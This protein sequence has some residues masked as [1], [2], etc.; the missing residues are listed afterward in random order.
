MA[1]AKKKVV[2]DA[3]FFNHAT[4]YEI[5]SSFFSKI[6]DANGYDPAMHYFVARVELKN[7]ELAQRLIRNGEIEVI[8]DKEF[9]EPES[10][11]DYSF[12]FQSVYEKIN[13]FP[14]VD[15]DVFVYGYDGS[16]AG[17]NLG[18]IRSAYLAMKSGYGLLLSDDYHSQ[19][20]KTYLSSSK[21]Q[22]EV[23]RLYDLIMKKPKGILWKDLKATVLR[24]Y[25]EDKR[26]RIYHLYND[27]GDL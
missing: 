19:I 23:E 15:E 17:Q 25:T 26:D 2:V 12:Y 9:I 18:E 22:I 10:Y 27:D 4:Q 11:E 6:L 1:Q 21:H 7:N 14:F 16:K 8:A 20:I 13:K 3:D 24:L 5:G